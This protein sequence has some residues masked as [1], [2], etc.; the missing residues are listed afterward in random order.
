MIAILGL[1]FLL[2]DWLSF[3]EGE[4][5]RLKLEVQGQGVEE[6]WTKIKGV[7]KVGKFSWTSYM[8]NPKRD[9]VKRKWT[10]ICNFAFY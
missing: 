7:L 10:I 9:F 8:Y 1:F 6:V 3:G 2:I 4:R 5:V